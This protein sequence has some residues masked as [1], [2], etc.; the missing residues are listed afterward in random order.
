MF[1]SVGQQLENGKYTIVK[2]IGA[3]GFGITYLARNSQ[4]DYVVIKTLSERLKFDL[5]FERFKHFFLKEASALA[6]CIHPHIV[7]FYEIITVDD[8]PCIVMEYIPGK[9]LYIIVTENGALPESEAVQIITQIGDALSTLHQKGLL[10]GDVSP[11]NIILHSDTLEAVLVDFGISHRFTSDTTTA[12]KGGL[13]IGYSPPEQYTSGLHRGA[14]TDVYALAATL[15]FLLTGTTPIS[16]LERIVEDI[17]LLA[18]RDI[19]KHISHR[20]SLAVLRGME[21]KVKPRPQSIETWLDLFNVTKSEVKVTLPFAFRNGMFYLYVFVFVFSLIAF[22]DGRITFYYLVL[23]NIGTA[24][25]IILIGV[26]KLRQDD[27]LSEKSSLDLTK[28]VIK[29][30]PLIGN[31]LDLFQL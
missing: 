7:R 3:G 8:F 21:L 23:N 22:F 27:R 18:P 6:L 16:A 25:F 14:Y 11:H 13:S 2:I 10:H 15:Y 19:N 24:M 26:L 1:W 9:N 29:Q 4:G 31:L 28:M 5:N 12:N 17:P 20:I 30:F